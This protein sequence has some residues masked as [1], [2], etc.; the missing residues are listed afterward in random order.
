LLQTKD[1][2]IRPFDMNEDIY[3]AIFNEL[4]D[5]ARHLEQQDRSFVKLLE[6]LYLALTSGALA[7]QKVSF[8]SAYIFSFFI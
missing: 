5:K 1:G 7:G 2:V 3:S 4:L 6:D 8:E